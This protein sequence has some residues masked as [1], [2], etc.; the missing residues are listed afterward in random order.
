[1]VLPAVKTASPT[2]APSPDEVALPVPAKLSDAQ[3][4]QLRR[5]YEAELR[6]YRVYPPPVAAAL[7]DI[8]QSYIN[9]GYRFEVGGRTAALADA[10]LA[11]PL[12]ERP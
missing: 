11:A 3:R 9:F 5:V 1:V 2:H 8:L 6:V 12:P 10:I 4:A 7:A